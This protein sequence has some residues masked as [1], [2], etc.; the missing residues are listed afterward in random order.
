MIHPPPGRIV[1][2]GKFAMLAW[3]TTMVQTAVSKSSYLSTVSKSSY[4]STRL[5]NDR[6]RCAAPRL[7]RAS[8]RKMCRKCQ[9]RLKLRPQLGERYE[10]VGIVI[11]K[12]VYGAL[13]NHKIIIVIQ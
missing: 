4:L 11:I 10:K 13:Y 5:T 7:H 8:E 6:N 9:Q 12:C 2:V 1:P 3:A